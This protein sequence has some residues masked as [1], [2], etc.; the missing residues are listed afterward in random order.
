MEKAKI[1]EI[2]LKVI[3]DEQM[4]CPKD[5]NERQLHYLM[6]FNDGALCL[7]DALIEYIEK[8]DAEQTVNEG[9]ENEQRRNH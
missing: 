8:Q 9:V 6:A 1:K 3:S 4:G 5:A 7:L 2:A